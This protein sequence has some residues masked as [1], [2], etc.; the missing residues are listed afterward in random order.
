MTKCFSSKYLRISTFTKASRRNKEGAKN[1]R[2]KKNC[3]LI[4][5]MILAVKNILGTDKAYI[6][7]QYASSKV[8]ITGITGPSMYN[9]S[10]ILTFI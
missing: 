9:L 2:I 10:L 7:M 6:D 8:R 3:V 1:I 4:F 5:F